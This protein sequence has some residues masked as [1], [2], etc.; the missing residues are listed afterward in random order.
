MISF[1]CLLNVKDR[2]Y[3]RDTRLGA[4]FASLITALA[5]LQRLNACAGAK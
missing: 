1:V 2:T 3:A 5:E 4:F